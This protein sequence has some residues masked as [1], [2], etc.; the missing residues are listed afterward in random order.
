VNIIIAKDMTGQDLALAKKSS[1]YLSKI[2]SDC[3]EVKEDEKLLIIG[4]HGYPDRKISKILCAGYSIA[5]KSLGIKNVETIIQEPKNKGDKAEEHIVSS[6]ENLDEGSVI[7]LT[8]S[9]SLGTVS[10]THLTLPTILR[11]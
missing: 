4:D 7:I 6:L 2:I 10:Y 8:I 1:S 9:N 3:L 5:A 11:V